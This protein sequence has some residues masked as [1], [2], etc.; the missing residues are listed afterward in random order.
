VKESSAIKFAKAFDMKTERLF[1]RNEEPLSPTT[2]LH[3]FRVLSVIMTSAMYDGY[4][5]DNPLRRVKPPKAGKHKNSYLNDE[6]AR[7]LIQ[8][9]REKAPPSVRYDH[10]YP[11]TDR[12]EKRG[13]L[14]TL[15]G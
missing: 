10:I 6:Q 2:I 13:V 7:Q 15:L 3:H 1:D 5:K 9:S 4:V 14:R 8:L 11:D 12:N